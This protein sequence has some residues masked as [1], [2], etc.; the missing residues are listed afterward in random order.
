MIKKTTIYYPADWYNL[1]CMRKIII[2][3]LFLFPL[4]ILAQ[5]N[6]LLKNLPMY[7]LKPIHFGFTVGFN[8]MDFVI[9]KSDSFLMTNGNK[10]K[11]DE[12]Y[13]IECE[14]NMGINLGPIINFR[15]APFL[16][17]RFLIVLS[18][19]QRNLQYKILDDSTGGL[20]RFR[21]H[22]M[23]LESTFLEFPS[24]VKF[25][26]KRFGNFRPYFIG[27]IN[28]KIDLAARKKIKEEERPKIRL[29]NFDLY[30]EL[31]AGFDFYFPY[32]KFST[33]VKYSGGIL[34]AIQQDGTQYTSSI[35]R[36]TSNIWYFSLHFE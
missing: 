25:K 1:I 14:S 32:F 27:G 20:Y 26:G 5:P 15:L 3:I 16:D 6:T 7:D 12:V 8:R 24:L 18:F 23:K 13:G 9:N 4:S 10:F 2:T 33:E 35:S 21:T 30:Y 11:L 29:K 17:L 22:T 31:G 34:N 28:P 36:L 19:G